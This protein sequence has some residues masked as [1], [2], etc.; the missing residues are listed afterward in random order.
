[1]KQILMSKVLYVPTTPAGTPIMYGY[2]G[3]LGKRVA[4]ENRDKAIANLLKDFSHMPYKNWEEMEA[5][6]YTIVEYT[7]STPKGETK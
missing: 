7:E 2:G 6:G 5:R 1:M 3:M 4:S